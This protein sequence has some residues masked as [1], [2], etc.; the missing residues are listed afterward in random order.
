MKE[1]QPSS[2]A[3]NTLLASLIKHILDCGVLLGL[4]RQTLMKEG[5][6]SEE[7]LA[8][9][10][11]QLALAKVERLVNYAARVLDDQ[12]LSLTS[13]RHIGLE[14][15][16]VV[17]HLMQ[18]SANLEHA[19]ELQQRYQPLIGNV[20]IIS[21]HH[22]PGIAYWCW[23]CQSSDT[24]FAHYATEFALGLWAL[25]T[26]PLRVGTQPALLGVHFKH[27]AP[28]DST[29]LIQYERHFACPVYF[30]QPESGLLLLPAALRLP[31]GGANASLQQTLEQYARRQLEQQQFR[32]ALLSDR[33]R[34]RLRLNLRQGATSREMIAAE[35]KMSVRTLSRQLQQEGSSYR[36]ILDELRLELAKSYL[37]DLQE[38]IEDIAKRLGFQKSPSFIS[39]FRPLV[40]CTPGEYQKQC[41]EAS[42]GDNVIRP[43]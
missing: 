33:V 27:A 34:A 23:D 28:K 24:V 3:S 12:L 30:G 15:V 17:G 32:P 11:Q 19:I 40:G 18:H 29:L 5:G 31:M 39:W 38:S 16:G 42:N 13:L 25:L 35:L 22:A 7:Q 6:F 37:Q 4:D 36:E 43:I 21:L 9:P 41:V 26:S 8:D 1:S 14:A 10:E 20:G 2:L